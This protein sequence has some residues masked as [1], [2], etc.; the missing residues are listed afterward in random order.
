MIPGIPDPSYSMD[1]D[2]PKSTVIPPSL[3][4]LFDWK[5]SYFLVECLI[6]NLQIL[7]IVKWGQEWTKVCDIDCLSLKWKKKSG[8]I[9]GQALADGIQI[10]HFSKSLH[11]LND[12]DEAN[13]LQFPISNNQDVSEE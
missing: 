10:K 7:Q 4:V 12:L 13:D 5:P 2:N 8:H 1:F 6:E 3:M 11:L 9:V